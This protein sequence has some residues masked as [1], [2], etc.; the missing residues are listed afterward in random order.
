M[1]DVRRIDI[2]TSVRTRK[3]SEATRA[4]YQIGGMELT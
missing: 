4:N 1:V 2:H 3:E